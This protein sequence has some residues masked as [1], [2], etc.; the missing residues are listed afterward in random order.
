MPYSYNDLVAEIQAWANRYDDYFVAQI[1]SF[2]NKGINKIYNQAKNIGFQTST[3]ANS[4]LVTGQ[5]ILAKPLNWKETISFQY[6]TPD[7]VSNFL[8][9]RSYEFCVTYYPNPS[10]AN[11]APLF[12]ADYNLSE[13]SAL[14]PQ[15]S[16]ALGQYYIVPTPDANYQYILTYL[17]LP[18]FDVDHQ[19]NFLTDRFPDLLFNAAMTYA[20]PFLKDDERVPVFDS[21][22]KSSLQ[23][24]NRETVERYTD[25]TSKRDKD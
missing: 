5:N 12:Y 3:P 14:P 8:L 9:P 17:G 6:I 4:R 7:G 22:Y 21:L 13:V 10:S 23:D 25:R 1:P 11:A 15:D 24:I 2:I 19:Q 20:E 18:L 16:G